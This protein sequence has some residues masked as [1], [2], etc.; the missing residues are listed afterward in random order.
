M[1]SVGRHVFLQAMKDLQF[2]EIDYYA[3][4]LLIIV[5]T[6]NPPEKRTI[7]CEYF[8]MLI[9]INKKKSNKQ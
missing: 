7:V 3:T 8:L 5:M 9:R 6:F 2:K 1:K 4:M